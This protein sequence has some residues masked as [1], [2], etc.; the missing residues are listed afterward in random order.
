MRKIPAFNSFLIGMLF[1]RGFDLL[2]QFFRYS[3]L[4]P[5]DADP[6]NYWLYDFG[7][8]FLAYFSAPICIGLSALFGCFLLR[9]LSKKNQRTNWIVFAVIAIAV[10]L[11]YRLELQESH[12]QLYPHCTNDSDVGII[13]LDGYP[14]ENIENPWAF[15]AYK[16]MVIPQV[17]IRNASFAEMIHWLQD[18]GEAYKSVAG[19]GIEISST[20][21]AE[22]NLKKFNI[23]GREMTILEVVDEMCWQMNCRWKITETGQILLYSSDVETPQSD[24]SFEFG[25]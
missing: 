23:Y 16:T 22:P 10:C 3:T 19:T 5:I 6:A 13:E 20:F 12:I 9:F 17:E 2:G 4:R 11:P 15:D 8:F 21:T 25:E 7:D 14:I 18:A 24:N 1:F